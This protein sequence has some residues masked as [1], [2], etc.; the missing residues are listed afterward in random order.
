LTEEERRRHMYIIGATGTGK[1]TLLLSMMIQDMQQKRGLAVLDPHG[2]LA[3]TVLQY[4]PENRKD[5]LIYFNPDDLEYP[6]GINVMELTPGL[7][8]NDALREKEF[9]AE[10][11]ISL[12]RK[13]FASDIKGNPHRIE[14]ILRNTIHT[15]FT[16]QHPTLF[17]IF[18]LLNNPDFQKIVVPK[19]QDEN[20]KNFWKYELKK[21]GE[22]QRVKMVSPIT[23]RIGR[24]L[25]SP[26]AKRILE[27]PT[28][29]INFDDILNGKIFVCNLAKGKL[30]EDTSQ[31]LGIML[32]N[33]LQLASL[34]RTRIAANKRKDFYLYVDEFQNF[35]TRSFVNMLSES[36]KYRLN[37]TIA[38]QS[39][40]QQE[41][42]DLVHIILANVGT[43]VCFKT[44]N[45]QD[46]KLILP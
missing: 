44:A 12:F 24:F 43:I 34:K 3:E 8:E 31:V 19:L 27:Q 9:I 17:T 30:G 23:A 32:L 33:K 22:Y 2:E 46:E 4:I 35:A 41:E 14:Y 29:T 16:V 36:R 15:A 7:S 39:T 6:I 25:F 28:S 5:D 11:V 38:E 10:S 42:K 37:L 21:A 1:S 13:V 18:E 26:S 20:L 40:S 45:P